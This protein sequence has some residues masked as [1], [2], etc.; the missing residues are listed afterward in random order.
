[1]SCRWGIR[2]HARPSSIMARGWCAQRPMASEPPDLRSVE[3][4]RSQSR[5]SQFWRSGLRT[6]ANSAGR[7]FPTSNGEGKRLALPQDPVD[8]RVDIFAAVDLLVETAFNR[9]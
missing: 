8:P 9:H 7:Y 6:P 5:N 3:I 4:W 1:M 2:Y